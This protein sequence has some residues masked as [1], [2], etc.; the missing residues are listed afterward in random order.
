M[1]CKCTFKLVYPKT[2]KTRVVYSGFPLV[3]NKV[4]EMGECPW[5]LPIVAPCRNP[6]TFRGESRYFNR[7]RRDLIFFAQWLR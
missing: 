6:G 3:F 5:A 1:R 4:Q 7:F 2:I